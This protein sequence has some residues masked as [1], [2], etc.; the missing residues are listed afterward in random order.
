MI[1][2]KSTS[3]NNFRTELFPSYVAPSHI[4]LVVL[5]RRRNHY[6]CKLGRALQGEKWDMNSSICER[7]FAW[8]RNMT[9]RCGFKWLVVQYKNGHSLSNSAFIT[10]YSLCIIAGNKSWLRLFSRRFC[11]GFF[12][13]I[14]WVQSDDDTMVAW[15]LI[16]FVWRKSK[17][18]FQFFWKHACTFVNNAMLG[19]NKTKRSTSKLHFTDEMKL[20]SNHFLPFRVKNRFNAALGRKKG[21][22]KCK[23]LF[24]VEIRK[25]NELAKDGERVS[26]RKA[27]THQQ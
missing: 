17:N 3:G 2:S 19:A 5:A 7:Y 18:S 6:V 11:C 4:R 27:H 26:K 22:E 16:T 1:F 23:P 12:D 8:L 25:Y 15:K 13:D 10:Q 24:A 20:H 21:V 14:S 9:P